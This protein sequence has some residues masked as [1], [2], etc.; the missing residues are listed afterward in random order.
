MFLRQTLIFAIFS[1]SIS[2]TGTLEATEQIEGS[3]SKG[4]R[5]PSPSPAESNAH[6]PLPDSVV[7]SIGQSIQS[8]VN[9][10]PAGTAFLI[11]TGIHRNQQVTP[12]SGNSFVGEEGAILSGAVLLTTFT[13]EGSYFVASGRDESGQAV[14]QCK[15]GYPRC[16]HPENLFFN[17]VPLRHVASLSE[18]SD[19]T[20]WFFDYSNDK[21]YFRKN[22]AGQKVELSS[23]RFAFANGTANNVLIR[24]LTIEKYA[25]PAQMAAIG[26]HSGAGENWKVEHNILRW[27]H[28]SGVNLGKNGRAYKNKMYENGGRG[29]GLIWLSNQF[30]SGAVFEGNTSY[31]HCIYFGIDCGWD[32]GG[33]KFTRGEN[34]LVKDNHVY[35]NDGRGLW[36]DVFIKNIIYEGNIVEN[37]VGP[38]INH[39]L[40]YD[41][42][43]RNN[44]VKG[45][46]TG[47]SIWGWGAQILI[48]NSTD[49]EVHDNTVVV[50]A[51]ADGIAILNSGAREVSIAN[52]YA[53]HNDVTFLGSPGDDATGGFCDLAAGCTAYYNGSVRM[54]YN[55]Y[56]VPRLDGW[57]FTW[58]WNAITWN[59]YRT[60]AAP[61]EQ[62]STIDTNIVP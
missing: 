19:D 18:V 61:Q 60:R 2:C 3:G 24:G 49:V 29:A 43:V 42:I 40:S 22:P 26:D 17:D 21:V 13:Q 5:P 27:I 4:K 47:F 16:N 51:N 39:E 32:G 35:E 23:S 56:H 52:V 11:K 12:K 36:S 34:I 44:T 37:N 7:V 30:I 54:D 8:A 28:G 38:G 48:Q 50:P 58:E 1:A 20:T 25:S 55:R 31:R 15:T 9:A 33:M 14:G 46:G 59:D 41:A 10:N 57:Y 45:N 62:N 6:T 53:H